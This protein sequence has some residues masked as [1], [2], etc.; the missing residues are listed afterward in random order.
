MRLVDIDPTIRQ[1][2]RYAGSDNFLGRPA[3][4]Y[5][6]PVC[7]LTERAAKALSKVQQSVAATG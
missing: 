1:D 6:A 5:E 2:M 7:I 3:R 4:G